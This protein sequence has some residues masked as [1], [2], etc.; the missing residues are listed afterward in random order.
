MLRVAHRHRCHHPRLQGR[1]QHRQRSAAPI[2]HRS[3]RPSAC[4][5]RGAG[6]RAGGDWG[7]S[8]A[9]PVGGRALIHRCGGRL[10]PLRLRDCRPRRGTA[11]V[12]GLALGRRELRCGTARPSTLR[13][14]D[15]IAGQMSQVSSV[16]ATATPGAGRNNIEAREAKRADMLAALRRGLARGMG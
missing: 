11:R 13:S 16:K 12:D 14:L 8:L 5:P 7:L 9:P 3:A 4:D 10:R 15:G 6:P 2:P 1:G